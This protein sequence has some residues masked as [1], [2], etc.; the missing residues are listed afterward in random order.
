MGEGFGISI[1]ILLVNLGLLAA[2]G[3]AMLLVFA[4]FDRVGMR[5]VKSRK[6]KRLLGKYLPIVKGIAWV[7]YGIYLVYLIVMPQPIVGGVIIVALGLASWRY[8]LDY[9]AGIVFRMQGNFSIGQRI[10]SVSVQGSI[11]RLL[12]TN[13]EIKGER[14][15]TY[16][17]PY[18]KFAEV[19]V[20]KPSAFHNLKVLSFSIHVRN[21]ELDIPAIK[22]RV[23]NFPWVIAGAEPKVELKRQNEATSEVQIVVH[24]LHARYFPLIESE[25]RQT[26]H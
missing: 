9:I 7:C 4:L 15:E 22:S 19:I 14:G 26:F 13:V 21:D 10:K 18:S 6:W 17:V 3:G 5:L 25:I 24:A 2:L 11:S 1:Y 20:E 8:L 16:L 12:S 23:M